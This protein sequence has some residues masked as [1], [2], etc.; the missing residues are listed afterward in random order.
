[1]PSKLRVGAGMF[2]SGIVPWTTG[3]L[4][5]RRGLPVKSGGS[6]GRACSCPVPCDR[7]RLRTDGE[8]AF[9][10]DLPTVMPWGFAPFAGAAGV[11]LADP[12]E[13]ANCDAGPDMWLTFRA[14]DRVDVPERLFPARAI[15]A[16]NSAANSAPA[17]VLR[18]CARIRQPLSVRRA[19]F[20]SFCC[21]QSSLA[22]GR[23][24][25]PTARSGMLPTAGNAGA[26]GPEGS[27]GHVRAP[28]KGRAGTQV[29]TS[30]AVS[31]VLPQCLPLRSGIRCPTPRPPRFSE[32]RREA[33]IDPPIRFQPRGRTRSLARKELGPHGVDRR[34]DRGLARPKQG[35]GL[36]SALH[37]E[38]L[39]EIV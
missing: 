33:T 36:V 15:A 26:V 6:S 5:W 24:P 27:A 7:P 30:I 14:A 23:E 32:T 19:G 29:P 34:E 31:H 10:Y 39:E 35:R 25:W 13:L 9:L 3:S 18:L 1:M 17:I 21:H 16:R 8:I 28:A 38:L 2:G 20:A 4:A 12:V 11:P 37:V 22:V